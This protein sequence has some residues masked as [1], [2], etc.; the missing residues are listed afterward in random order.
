MVYR[1]N[2]VNMVHNLSLKQKLDRALGM[3]ETR[4]FAPERRHYEGWRISQKGSNSARVSRVE[5]EL[6]RRSA[7]QFGVAI[8]RI[9]AIQRALILIA[10]ICAGCNLGF[11]GEPAPAS[12]EGAPVIKIASP[13]PNQIFLA[14]STVIV[15][16][17]VENAGPDLARISVLLD[18]ALLGEK[19]NPNE[20]NAAV[21]P[22]TLDWP[23]SS[24]GEFTIS[25]LAER[26]DGA[27]AREDV[28]VLVVAE[29]GDESPTTAVSTPVAPESASANAADIAV[30]GTMLQPAR[31]RQGPGA[32][33]DLVGNLDENQEIA[34]VAVNAT[35]TWVRISYNDLADAWVY[36]EFVSPSGDLSQLPVEAGPPLPTAGGVNLVLEE[37]RIAAPIVCGQQSI[38]LARIRNAGADETGSVAWV[39][40]EALLASDGSA[41]I[42]DPPPTYLN[43]L[44]ADEESMIEIPIVLTRQVDEEQFIRVVV[45]SGNHLPETDETDN[46]M[47]S[48]SFVLQR[49]DCG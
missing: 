34:I 15:Q 30:A 20:T 44:K 39:I 26:G 42:D 46:T 16:A 31:I 14:G 9:K 21:L 13:S 37:V 10:L 19:L 25:V 27:S 1:L 24:A 29:A 49:G 28:R 38:V 43:T 2:S 33:Y 36:A 40:A 11:T 8:E 22:L 47:N 6:L 35:G 7:V 23:T 17:R 3:R 32:T 48:A 4:R 41:L 5:R 12:F 18:E 45:D